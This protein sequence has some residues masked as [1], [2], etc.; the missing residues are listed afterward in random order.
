MTEENKENLQQD[1]ESNVEKT[2]SEDKKDIKKENI[3]AISD[4]FNFLKCSIRSGYL[5]LIISMTTFES[6]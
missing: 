6:K 1:V 5:P 4:D 3:W 2:L